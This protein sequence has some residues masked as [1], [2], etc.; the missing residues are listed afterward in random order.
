MNPSK[1]HFPRLALAASWL[2]IA[3]N[4]AAV[5]YLPTADEQVLER[6]P[7]APTDPGARELRALREDL[8]RQPERLDLAVTLAR[9]YTELGRLKGDPRFAGYAQAALA[10]WWEEAEPPAEVLLVRAT[11][12]QRTHD[13]DA[14]LADLAILLR[15]NP[16]DGQARLTRATI[17]QVQGAFDAAAS[18]CAALRRVAP[19]IVWAACAYGLAGVNGRLRDS[20][21]A[22]SALL[23]R[24]PETNPEVKAWV[25]SMLAEMAARAGLSDAA[26]A[27]F[28]EALSIDPADHY[29]LTAYA[30]WLL[31]QHRPAQV[32][33]LL[34]RQQRTDAL[35]LRHALALKALKSPDLAAAVEQ[36][37]ARFAASRLRGDRVHLREE[38]RF[39]VELL[40]DSQAAL[41]LARDNWAVQKEVPDLRLLLETALASK[42]VAAVD[43]V[44]QWLARSRAEDVVISRL[45]R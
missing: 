9:R 23:P 28:R 22:L 10:R 18:E 41:A 16:R 35:L 43:S 25:L 44:R 42:D 17:L 38:A 37:R 6:L 8:A 26:E 33:K 39:T 12:R 27:H 11:L 30:D 32:V 7:L 40:G 19:E 3:A 45:L 36:L 29:L 5:P 15:R 13:F 34:E 1:L 21:D 20:Y 24:Q 31:D 14:A 4:V 2:L